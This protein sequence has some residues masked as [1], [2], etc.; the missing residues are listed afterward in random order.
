M[1]ELLSAVPQLAGIVEKGGV[2]GLLLL[3]VVVLGYEVFRLRKELVRTYAQRDQFRLGYA[4]C[5]AEC[6]RNSL[7]PDLSMV[8]NLQEVPA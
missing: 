8:T 2:I 4:I 3:V 5:K 6:E 7:H 1:G